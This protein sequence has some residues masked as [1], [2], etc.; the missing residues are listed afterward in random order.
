M[1]FEPGLLDAAFSVNGWFDAEAADVH[2]FTALGASP[3]V[4]LAA[5]GDAG[6]ICFMGRALITSYSTGAAVGETLPFTLSGVFDGAVARGLILLNGQVGS[7]QAQSSRFRIGA[8][9]AQHHLLGLAHVRA[10]TGVARSASLQRF[11]AAA[12]GAAVDTHNFTAA[13]GA[14]TDAI[15]VDAVNAAEYWQV[16]VA[17]GEA[18]S[19]FVAAGIF[20]QSLVV[21]ASPLNP[22]TPIPPTPGSHA[23]RAGVSADDTFTAPEFTAMSTTHEITLP[24]FSQNRYLAFAVPDAENDITGLL[25]VGSGLNQF[26]A[27]ERVTGVL[28]IG[29]TDYKVWRSMDVVFPVNSGTTW[30]VVQ[31]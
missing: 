11:A 10:T 9:T 15:Q 8:V 26:S 6:T 25:V 31:A 19:V 4:A 2:L 20:N 24:T 13:G 5:S 7:G 16:A 18:G 29:G 1:Q 21:T 27:F 30:Q 14:Y 28:D 22:V 3:Y 23:R 12:G 17:A